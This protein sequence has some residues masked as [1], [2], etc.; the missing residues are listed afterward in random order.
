[1]ARQTTSAADPAAWSRAVDGAFLKKGI[2]ARIRSK[3]HELKDNFREIPFNPK[4][5]ALVRSF[6]LFDPNQGNQVAEDLFRRANAKPGQ[7]RTLVISEVHGQAALLP[8]YREAL[9]QLAKLPNPV[10]L[11]EYSKEIAPSVL[12]DGRWAL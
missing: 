12:H 8:L 3:W 9:E 6:P 5:N 2:F 4:A 7:P 1:L 10:Y 11:S